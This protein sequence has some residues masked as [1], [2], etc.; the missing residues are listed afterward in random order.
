V[1]GAVAGAVIA[2]A[3]LHHGPSSGR[4]ARD[5]AGEGS[6]L[7]A[8]LESYRVEEDVPGLAAAVVLDGELVYCG[9]LGVAESGRSRRVDET[10]PFLI[11]SVSKIITGVVVLQLV[12]AG[13]IDL[14][15]PARRYIPQLEVNPGRLGE[16]PEIL[17]RHLLAHRSG[18]RREKV[19][20]PVRLVESGIETGVSLEEAIA[21]EPLRYR[22]G[23]DTSYSNLNYAL[24]AR[25]VESVEGK[26]YSQVLDER[27]LTPLGMVDSSSGLPADAVDRAAVGHL[28][29]F[30]LMD[31]M[32]RYL[33]P[34]GF[35][36]KLVDR[37]PGFF[38]QVLVPFEVGIP[39]YG[40]VV[41]SARDLGIFLRFQLDETDEVFERALSWHS[42]RRMRDPQLG[43]FSWSTSLARGHRI[44][45]HTGGGPGFKS[46]LA[47]IPEL[48]F[49]MAVLANRFVPP[50]PH[51]L[52][53]LGAARAHA[54][55]RG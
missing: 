50:T 1:L 22:P 35:R 2:C 11:Y 51:P 20:L 43:S 53:V 47:I 9:G 15:A 41:A 48:G 5:N 31:W 21:R 23:A 40:D 32:M 49:G 26:P 3:A 27:L 33:Y 6:P 13:K 25:I 7:E 10:T 37:R 12:E 17:I 19:G 52:E 45:S 4:G 30:S 36:K 8:L 38:E 55:H 34:S 54:A 28:R 39:G 29:R 16:Q 42:R 14:D 44:F 46:Y 24:L 18:W